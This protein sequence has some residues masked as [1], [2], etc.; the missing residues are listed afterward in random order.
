ML[1]A[2]RGKTPFDRAFTQVIENLVRR[3]LLTLRN[4]R[5]LFDVVDVEV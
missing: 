2:E 5:Q 3:A 4:C 1:A